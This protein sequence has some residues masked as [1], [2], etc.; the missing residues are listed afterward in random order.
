MTKIYEHPIVGIPIFEP[1]ETPLPHMKLI[2]YELIKPSKKFFMKP[3]PAKIRTRGWAVI[4]L[5]V[6]FFWPVMC[7]PCCMSWSYQ[8]YQVPVYA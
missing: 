7:V 6:L 5:S 4:A 1:L 3:D 2:G 8:E